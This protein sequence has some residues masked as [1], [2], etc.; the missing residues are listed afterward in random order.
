MFLKSLVGID[1]AGR[2]ALA[3]PLYM[4]ACCLKKDNLNLRDS[5][6]LSPKQRE[7]F[8]YEIINNSDFLILSFSNENIDKFGLSACLKKGLEIICMHFEK[9]DFLYDGN[10]NFN[11]SQ[12]K[13]L[14]KADSLIPC[15]SAASIL[16]KVSRDKFMI[17]IAKEFP[18]YHFEKHKAYPTALHKELITKFGPCTLHRKSFKLT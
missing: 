10:T 9:S 16:A 1:E 13:T 7:K 2:G 3:G 18:N 12:V 6:K 4:A 5:K 8:F 15:V 11:V 17:D 14:I